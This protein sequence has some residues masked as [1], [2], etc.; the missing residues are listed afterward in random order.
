MAS[1]IKSICVFC[2][3]SSGA[4][5]IFEQEA[6][7]LGKVL[8]ENNITL[9][10]G[11][12]SIG[13]MGAIAK[14]VLNNGGKGIAIVPEPLYKYS[15]KQIC[16]TIIVPD[17]HARKKR[18][19][20]ECDAFIVLPGGYGTMEEMLEMI[21][22]SQLNIHSKPIILLN[23]KNYFKLFVDWIQLSVQENFIHPEN[24]NIFVLCD[25]TKDIITKLEEYKAPDS[26]YG[27]DWSSNDKKALV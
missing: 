7:E 4:D 23:T 15:S 16:E 3:S 8:A 19:E 27:I 13:L 10:Y 24:R 17:M 6:R 25:S 20:E 12:G 21:T 5:P 2:G 26:R 11:G 1:K 22:W 14:E 9:V 18:M